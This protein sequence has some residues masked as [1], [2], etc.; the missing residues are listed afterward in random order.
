MRKGE[1]TRSRILAAAHRAF[2]R[3][4]F[5]GAGLNAILD[6]SGAPRGSL[7]F[8]F[9]GG[10]E[11]LALAAISAGI[12]QLL[13]PMVGALRGARTASAGIGRVLKLLGDRLEA[14]DFDKG[15]PIC[16]IVASSANAPDS[17]RA[18]AANALSALE[19]GLADY[20]KSHGHAAREAERLATVVVAAIE[21]ALLMSRI[22]RTCEPLARVAKTLPALLG[23]R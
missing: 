4:G 8:H 20:L 15:C 9:P 21:G 12:E 13:A 23:D 1:Q 11:E 3:D 14:A 17:V 22:Q 10:K 7:Y 5:T 16:S 19:R 6:D 2:K 18:A